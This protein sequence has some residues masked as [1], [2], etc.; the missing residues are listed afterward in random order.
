LSGT[1]GCLTW[2]ATTLPFDPHPQSF[3]F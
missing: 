1:L 2:C 3:C